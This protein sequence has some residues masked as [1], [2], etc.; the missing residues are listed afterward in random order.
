MNHP[1]PSSPPPLTQPIPLPRE[2]NQITY[3]SEGS[4]EMLHSQQ[5]KHRPLK[6][7]PEIITND[8]IL[9]AAEEFQQSCIEYMKKT[10]IPP[11]GEISGNIRIRSISPNPEA[12][13]LEVTEYSPSGKFVQAIALDFS[14]KSDSPKRIFAK[15]IA[16]D[17]EWR[18]FDKIEDL[19][20]R[21]NTPE[22]TLQLLRASKNLVTNNL[23][24]YENLLQLRK[25]LKT[26]IDSMQSDKLIVKPPGTNTD[27]TIKRSRNSLDETTSVQVI[28]DLFNTKTKFTIPYSQVLG[29]GGDSIKIETYDQSADRFNIDRFLMPRIPELSKQSRQINSATHLHYLQD[30]ERKVAGIKLR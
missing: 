26:A 12:R 27:I 11:R 2:E 29:F 25:F 3:F 14:A 22:Q 7:F 21:E 24:C 8:V 28:L 5:K 13:R 17:S 18:R 19:M 23:M 20:K 4:R 15:K 10:G 1:K 9:A 6:P 30:L 16:G